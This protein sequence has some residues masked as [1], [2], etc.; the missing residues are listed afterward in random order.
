MIKNV[1]SL[2]DGVSCGQVAL[3][4]AGIKYKNYYASEIDKYAIQV[5]QKNYPKTIQIGDVTK[6][7]TKDLPKIDLLM[8]GSP[9]QGFSN[10]GTK[11]NF[12]DPRSKLFFDFVRILKEL[13]PKYFL[14]EN[15]KM[16]QEWQDVISQ[17]VGVQPILINSSLVSGQNRQRLYWSN[18]PNISQPKDKGIILH[19]VLETKG[20][21]IKISKR[22]VY[23]RF[24]HKSSCL[25]AG[26]NSGG[27]HSDM[28]LIGQKMNHVGDATD[29]K[30]YDI[31]KRIYSK[32]GKSPT[33][34]T[35]TSGNSHIKISL[36][37]YEYR[38]L[39]PIECER[40]QTLPDNYTEGV[41][42]SQRYKAIGNGWTVNVIT[43]IFKHMK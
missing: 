40:L 23:K 43:H 13:K 41:S 35:V 17:Y 28:D 42:N 26:G 9:C 15:V 21:Y 6:L 1:L 7:A 30:G 24:Q 10:A 34:T 38:R 33:V 25:T 27:N 4:K 14:L 31:I 29:I 39:M 16:K 8:A 19:D 37:D 20:E 11:L 12:D 5:T 2:F 18:I 36:S 32:Y 22:G 3:E